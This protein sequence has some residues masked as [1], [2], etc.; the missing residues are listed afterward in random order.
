VP[1]PWLIHLPE[2]VAIWAQNDQHLSIAEESSY[3]RRGDLPRD[4]IVTGWWK[5]MADRTRDPRVIA[6][7]QRQVTLTDFVFTGGGAALVLGAGMGN[8][9]LHGMDYLAIRWMAWGLGLF[10]ASGLIWILVLIP[11]Q[12]KQARMAKQFESGAAIPAN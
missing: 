11:I 12:I 1:L 7:A 2:A 5:F 3:L 10:I 4:I 9:V 8:A 6:F